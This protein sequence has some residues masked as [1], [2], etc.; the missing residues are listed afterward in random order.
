[1]TGYNGGGHNECVCVGGGG[2]DRE[3]QRLC[4]LLFRCVNLRL[5]QLMV[6]WGARF[7]VGNAAFERERGM[8]G[9][10]G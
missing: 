1:M 4:L 9:G 7:G 6:V 3:R 10:G 8:R 2:G 5:W